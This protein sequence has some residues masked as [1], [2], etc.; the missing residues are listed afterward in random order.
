MKRSYHFYSYHS[1]DLAACGGSPPIR[2]RRTSPRESWWRQPPKG[3]TAGMV[4][5]EFDS[6]IF[7]H[8]PS[9]PLEVIKSLQRLPSFH[10][11]F[12]PLLQEV[13]K[14][15]DEDTIFIAPGKYTVPHHDDFLE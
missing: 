5:E 7:Y 8:F 13:L 1:A 4:Q 10:S 9:F 14:P 3:E 12:I 11:L 2:L 6:K 15:H